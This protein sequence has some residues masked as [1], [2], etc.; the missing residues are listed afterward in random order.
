M[1]GDSEM[2]LA[3][4]RDSSDSEILFSDSAA[5]GRKNGNAEAVALGAKSTDRLDGSEL[6]WEHW[7]IEPTDLAA[8]SQIK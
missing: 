7:N 4:D 2:S 8:S 5:N 3:A 1:W 6:C